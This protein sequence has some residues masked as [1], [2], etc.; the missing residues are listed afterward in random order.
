MNE[1]FSLFQ[2][3][4]NEFQEVRSNIGGQDVTSNRHICFPIEATKTNSSSGPPIESDAKSLL[5]LF[6]DCRR[7]LV[8][9]SHQVDAILSNLKKKI[10]LHDSKH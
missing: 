2:E 4:D 8:I 10:A 1:L 5:S 9:L 6:K 3:Y 7:D